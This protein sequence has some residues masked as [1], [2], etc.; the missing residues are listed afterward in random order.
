MLGPD[1][2][3]VFVQRRCGQTVG[4]SDVLSPAS[5]RWFAC[6]RAGHA[7]DVIAQ[8]RDAEPCSCAKFSSSST[9]R[10]VCTC[11]HVSDEHVQLGMS[12]YA[13]FGRC[14]SRTPGRYQRAVETRERAR[15]DAD[16]DARALLIEVSR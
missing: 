2:A 6:F 8:A 10:Y 12:E 1:G 3:V 9:S 4:V 11:G 14:E 13:F 16:E 7:A 15:R 5:G